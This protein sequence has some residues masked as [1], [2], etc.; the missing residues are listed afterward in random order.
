[1]S[2]QGWQEL[3]DVAGVDDRVVLHGGAAAVVRVDP[4]RADPQADS[5]VV[6]THVSRRAGLDK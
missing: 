3:L 2:E 4:G 5:D 6:G 1:M